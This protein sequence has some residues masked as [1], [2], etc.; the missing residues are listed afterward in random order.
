MNM[1]SDNK[2]LAVAIEDQ[3]SVIHVMRASLA[4]L[5]IEILSAKDGPSG[6]ALVQERRPD[7]VLLDLALPGIDGWQ[8]LAQIRQFADP[9]EIAVIIV[10]AHEDSGSALEAKNRGANEF[11]TKPFRPS[12]LH[13]AVVKALGVPAVDAP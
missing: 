11:L 10:T 4:S 3:A 13:D 6:L 12:R 1:V 9:S 2:Y 8:V 7:V 5:P